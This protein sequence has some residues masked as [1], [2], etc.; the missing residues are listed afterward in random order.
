[1]SP[2]N[3]FNCL[4]E[5]D[6]RLR[7]HKG[8]VITGKVC[9]LYFGA[10]APEMTYSQIAMELKLT[11]SQV[12]ARLNKARHLIHTDARFTPVRDRMNDACDN[13]WGD[14]DMDSPEFQAKYKARLKAHIVE[15]MGDESNG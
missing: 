13:K 10:D 1:M 9:K 8:D 11:P 12:Q 6:Y 3:I 5:L 14:P 15:M 4:D 2:F 7:T